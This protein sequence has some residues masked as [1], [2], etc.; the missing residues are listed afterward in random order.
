MLKRLRAHLH[1]LEVTLQEQSDALEDK[2]G[3]LRSDFSSIMGERT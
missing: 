2:E 3:K 1:S